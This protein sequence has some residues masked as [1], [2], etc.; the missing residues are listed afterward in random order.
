MLIKHLQKNLKIII[1]LPRYTKRIIAIIV[2]SCFCIIALW[3]ALYLR[4]DTYQFNNLGNNIIWAYGI[5]VSISLGVFWL[6]GLYRTMFRYSSASLLVSISFAVLIYG[7][8]YFSIISIFGIQG[9]PRSI[10]VLQ[11]LIFLFVVSASRLFASFIF[12]ETY[13][14]KTSTENISK[15]LIYGAGSAGNQLLYALGNSRQMKVYGFL[16][17]DSKLEGQSLD[18]KK[19]F[20]PNDLNWLIEKKS[21]THILLA[22]PSV[23]RFKRLKIIKKLNKYKII[24]KTLPSVSDIISEKVTTSD[25]RELDIEDLLSR[26]QV[27]PDSKLLKMNISSKKIIVTGAGGS[28]G[29]ELCRQILKLFPEKIVLLDISEFNLYK[30]TSE[31]EELK[32]SNKIYNQIEIIPVLASVQDKKRMRDI[33]KAWEPDTLYHAAAYK[34]VPL[35]EQNISEGIKNN[36]FGTLI[37]AQTA[38]EHNISNMVLV[39]TDKAVRPTNIMGASKRLS[40]LC[41]QALYQNSKEKKSKLSIVRFGN[42]L[43]SSGSV[44]NKFRKQLHN[45]GPVTLTHPDVTRFFM[46]ATEAAELVIQASSL[47]KG[48]DVFVLDMGE[49]IKIKD[50]IGNMIKLSGLSIQ[51]K[52][53]PE[54]DI[55]IEITG[56]RPGEK[57]YEELLLGENP[58]ETEHK[59][60]KRSEEPFISWSILH[61]ELIA[62]KEFIE[63]NDITQI[64]KILEKIVKGYKPN[65]NIVDKIYI[66]QIKKHKNNNFSNFKINENDSKIIKFKNDIA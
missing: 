22:L 53:N 66:K 56:L 8:M 19:I 17:D 3:L 2:D 34:H 63:K 29:S 64:I 46:T 27:L 52:K 32:Q 35:V 48:C 42:V 38:L 61:K 55:K 18:G 40:E 10:G 21:I 54:G 49:Q 7:L 20:S 16:D 25:I 24:I 15:C 12:N 11:P 31:L 60:I 4:L 9:I 26:E 43:G 58:T 13:L 14:K 44:V 59:K 5:S 28:I 41:L 1:S 57:L 62:L 37:A 65:S 45:G 51:D 50:L 6:M 23:N 33:F 47:S 39:S 36:V 30:I